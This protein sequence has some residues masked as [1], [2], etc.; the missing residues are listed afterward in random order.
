VP[1]DHF[2]QAAQ[3]SNPR[4]DG[5]FL[6]YQEILF[7]KIDLEHQKGLEI[8]A[9][10]LPFVTPDMG[11]VDFADQLP[12]DAL[13]R[14]AARSPGHSADFVQDVDFVLGETPLNTLASDYDWVA[15]S[16]LIEHAPDL[17]GWLKT[18][19]D[20]LS[21]KGV[22]FCVV[23]DGRFTFD[24]HR[25]LSTLGKIL[26]DHFD[27]WERPSFRDVF[28]ATYYSDNINAAD[29]WDGKVATNVQYHNNFNSAWEKALH[30]R[31]TYVDCHCN[32]FTSRSFAQIISALA[33]L[34]LIPF[35]VEEVGDTERYWI[36]FH[37]ILRKNECRICPFVFD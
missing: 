37:S 8:G 27:G 4:H 10:D 9:F 19:G 20:R 11:R 33:T 34:N 14:L 25:P 22:L 2:A 35:D 23:P 5:R 3:R 30:G 16:H 24:I 12:T 6:K 29:V 13:K 18:I 26:Q 21:P 15:T 32:I 1:E 17:V 31:S 36:D 7:S 28:D